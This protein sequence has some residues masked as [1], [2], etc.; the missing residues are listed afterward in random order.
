[1]SILAKLHRQLE[2]E[3]KDQNRLFKMIAWPLSIFYGVCVALRRKLYA[4]GLLAS[5]K[6]PYPSISIG[7]LIAGGSGKT[8]VVIALS[9]AI[10]ARG[11]KPC[12]LTRGYKSGLASDEYAFL[13]GTKIVFSE[14]N[15]TEDSFYAD[16]ARMAAALLK[17]VPVIVGAKR[18]E[19]FQW[20]LSQYVSEISHVILEDAFSHLKLHRDKDILLFDANRPFGNDQL[21]PMGLLREPA[22]ILASA[23]GVLITRDISQ[24]LDSKFSHPYTFRASFLFDP[25]RHIH[26]GKLLDRDQS[27]LLISGIAYPKKVTKALK[28]AGYQ[29]FNELFFLDHQR[30]DLLQIKEKSESALAIVITAKDFYR[31]PKMFLDLVQ[32]VYVCDVHARLPEEF[33]NFCLN[34]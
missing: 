30:I 5:R 6:L 25:P 8:P 18:F 12:I 28:D 7:N 1:M 23:D 27:F 33:V 31:Q 20:F 4:S 2:L 13:I 24:P 14:K 22:S 19:A 21:M 34:L 26:T 32:P 16:E 17:D 29:K 3:T 11:Y 9:S 10:K 15:K